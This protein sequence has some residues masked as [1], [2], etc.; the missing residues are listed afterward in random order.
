MRSVAACLAVLAVVPSARADWLVHLPNCAMDA[1]YSSA[2]TQLIY[3]R[4]GL[5]ALVRAGQPLV[6]RVRLPAPL[7]PP[8]GIQQE[9]A[10]RGWSAALLGQA[11]LVLSPA[12]FRYDLRV[13]DVRADTNASLVY[14]VTIVVPP[15][16]APGTYALQL[17][18]PGSSVQTL[19]GVV[20]VLNRAPVLRR[21]PVDAEVSDLRG[22][23]TDAWLVDGALPSALVGEGLP[24][25]DTRHPGVIFADESALVIGGCD[26]APGD[27]ARSVDRHATRRFEVGSVEAPRGG[28]AV[29]ARSLR[30][31]GDVDRVV[32]IVVP[33]D[34]RAYPLAGATYYPGTGVRPAGRL[35]SVVIRAPLTAGER[36]VVD[37]ADGS[38]DLD[39]RPEGPVHV[40]APSD[41][42][43][44]VEPGTR[45]AWAFEEDGEGSV[46]GDEFTLRF[47][48]IGRQEVH[49][50][51]IAPDGRSA[52]TRAVV[53]VEPVLALGCA[54]SSKSSGFLWVF[55][56]LCTIRRRRYTAAE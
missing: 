39:V 56:A 9:R 32:S 40:D 46:V 15:W 43:T 4:P 44:S 38:F 24:W 2:P 45:L 27:F 55:A 26:D 34:G 30:E 54:T 1:P 6:V 37:P 53:A 35:P 33:E 48:W 8:P 42:R 12:E 29:G 28:L 23:D 50:L 20:R 14:R 7:T 13:R 19:A 21:L 36:L 10:L 3:P 49:V 22:L 17:G 5:P 31:E 47:R 52:R 51:A 18:S 11:D 41:W 16:A 25:I